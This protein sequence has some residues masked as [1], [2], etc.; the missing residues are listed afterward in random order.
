V[1]S[2]AEM[3]LVALE[4]SRNIE[5]LQVDLRQKVIQKPHSGKLNIPSNTF[6]NTTFTY[7]KAQKFRMIP[8]R[9]SNQSPSPARK[10]LFKIKTRFNAVNANQHLV[11]LLSYI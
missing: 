11:I 2:L 1:S 10:S 8:P 9:Y 5:S 3:S 4:R 6:N 7:P